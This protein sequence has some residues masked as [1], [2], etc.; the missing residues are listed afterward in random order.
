M[1]LSTKDRL[2]KLENRRGVNKRHKT[3]SIVCDPKIMR[4]TDFSGIDADI[5]LILPDNG[6]RV[7]G[8]TVPEGSYLV[9]YSK[10]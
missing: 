10:Y 1:K 8:E 9:R 6:R 7:Y 3:A 5:L 4:S 2:K